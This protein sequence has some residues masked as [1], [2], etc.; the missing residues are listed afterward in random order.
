MET[1]KGRD[2]AEDAWSQ[3]AQPVMDP[4]SPRDMERKK[5]QQP[6]WEQ[7]LLQGIFNSKFLAKAKISNRTKIKEP[8]PYFPVL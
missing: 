1:K 7:L 8:L 2:L 5:E 3:V 6:E 4:H